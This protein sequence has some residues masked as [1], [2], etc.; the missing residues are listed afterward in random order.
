LREKSALLHA[1][2]ASAWQLISRGLGDP[3]QLLLSKLLIL[4]AKKKYI[5]ADL[6]MAPS[7]LKPLCL[8]NSMG[9]SHDSIYQ[10]RIGTG[11]A[12]KRDA[13]QGVG[14]GCRAG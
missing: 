3:E 4:K 1:Y 2:G 9:Q 10:T 6:Q 5:G 8:F 14:G 7:L 13:G 12:Q 11:A